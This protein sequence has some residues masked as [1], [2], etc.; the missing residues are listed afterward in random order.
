MLTPLEQIALSRLDDRGQSGH[1]LIRW[2]VN[3]YKLPPNHELIL[4][5]TWE[6]LYL[7]YMTDYYASN[8]KEYEDAVKQ[9][10]KVET[11]SGQTTKGYEEDLEKR[12]KNIPKVD[13]SKW[14]N[15]VSKGE[16]E[17]ED[18]FLG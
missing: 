17:F 13:L 6:E 3:K 5:L 11:W 15:D 1:F 7:E 18:N 14:Q 16:D 12:L 10:G 4:G 8:P 2:W 9:L